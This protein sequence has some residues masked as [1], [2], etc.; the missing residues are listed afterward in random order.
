[1]MLTMFQNL[2]IMCNVTKRFS[3]QQ[4]FV[5][6]KVL[7]DLNLFHYL[8]MHNFVFVLSKFMLNSNTKPWCKYYI[9]SIT[10]AISHFTVII[11]CKGHNFGFK[12]TTL[13][14]YVEYFKC[15]ACSQWSNGLFIIF[16]TAEEQN[17]YYTV[18]CMSKTKWYH[19][20]HL[21]MFRRR[22][23]LKWQ[24]RW[25]PQLQWPHQSQCHQQPLLLLTQMV[26]MLVCCFI[27]VLTVSG[28]WDPPCFIH[29]CE[30]T[31]SLLYFNVDVSKGSICIYHNHYLLKMQVCPFRRVQVDS[32]T[33]FLTITF[34]INLFIK[35][36]S[37]CI[38]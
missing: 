13:Y 38:N 8:F 11:I 9:N 1:M 24:Q 10:P 4:K 37:C 36:I 27:Y 19:M 32:P 28:Y 12:S 21:C 18:M 5:L 35:H 7:V 30:E 23:M 22:W 31:C 14:C 15:S 6:G 20:F 2:A 3:K 29:C 25:L 34:L 16:L 26:R 33:P 17:T